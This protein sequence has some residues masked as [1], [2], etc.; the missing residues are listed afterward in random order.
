MPLALATRVGLMAAVREGMMW[1]G[2][3]ADT[4][5]LTDWAT[6]RA[7]ELH[8]PLI[9]LERSD[10]LAPGSISKGSIPAADDS[11]VVLVL[12][13]F[14]YVQSLPAAWEEV[15]RVAGSVSNIFIAFMPKASFLAW[16]HPLHRPRYVLEAAPPTT[17]TMSARGTG[18]P[19]PTEHTAS[20]AVSESKRPFCLYGSRPYGS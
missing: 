12:Y 8:R 10:A 14:E 11:A 19:Y 17:H 7:E 13:A 18:K 6:H 9:T 4:K 1:K 16:L 5:R 2:R 15:E 3:R 20:C